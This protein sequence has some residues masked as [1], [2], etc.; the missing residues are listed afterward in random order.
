LKNPFYIGIVTYHG[1]EKKGSHQPL[2][3]RDLWEQVQAIR[4]RRA[5]QPG[6]AIV[7]GPGGLLTELAFCGRCGARLW[8]CQGRYMCGGRRRF[9]VDACDA[10]MLTARAIEPLVLDVI[11][12]CSLIAPLRDAVIQVVKDR[13]ARPTTGGDVD[14]SALRAQLTRLKELFEWGDLGKAEYLWKREQIQKQIAQI[15]THTP[16]LLDVERAIELL[17]NM[18][19]LIDAGSDAQLR[20]LLQTVFLT[21]WL[22][23]GAVVAIR[24]AP[25]FALLMEVVS[26][27]GDLGG[28]RTHNLQLRRL[29]LYPIELRGPATVWTAGF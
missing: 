17:G 15:Q 9:G 24:P 8:W 23:K 5:K 1:E 10:P 7:R 21:I 14:A 29:T 2:I 28:A 12:N 13:L 22:E 25:A 26:V 19:E 18:A 16:C 6:K 20:A 3:D 4:A 27:S 11:R